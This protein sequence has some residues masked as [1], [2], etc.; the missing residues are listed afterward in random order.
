MVDTGTNKQD[1]KFKLIMFSLFCY[2][3]TLG[4]FP[5]RSTLAPFWMD[6][7]LIH[8]GSV[9]DLVLC[10][11]RVFSALAS[12]HFRETLPNYS[13]QRH[14][15]KKS[16]NVSTVLTTYIQ[17]K[18]SLAVLIHGKRSFKSRQA[19]VSVLLVGNVS[20]ANAVDLLCRCFVI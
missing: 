11:L 16:K 6:K 15:A 20:A 19:S 2:L 17:R 1:V 8:V 9:E 12:V 3:I 7:E 14:G 4:S 5:I 10:S 18:N 13:K